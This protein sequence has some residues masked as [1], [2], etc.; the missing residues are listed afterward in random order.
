MK[1]T[2]QLQEAK[3]KFSKVVDRALTQGAQIVTRRGKKAVVVMPFEEYERLTQRTGSLA[4][5]L[6]A[7][8]LFGSE[9][10]IERDKSLP[11][12]FEIEP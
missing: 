12:I 10:A 8:P 4:Q 6:M 2:W 7:S 11:R 5:F 1:N 9:L 3:S